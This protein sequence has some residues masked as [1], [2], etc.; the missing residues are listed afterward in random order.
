MRGIWMCGLLLWEVKRGRGEGEGRGDLV[1]SVNEGKNFSPKENNR[2]K[3]KKRMCYW[4]Q[5]ARIQTD[6]LGLPVI[7]GCFLRASVENAVNNEMR[8]VLQQMLSNK[9]ILK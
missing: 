4:C 1:S 9:N 6:M 8:A 2:N 7:L 3:G 5:V